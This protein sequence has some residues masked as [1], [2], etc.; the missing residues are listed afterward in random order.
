MTEA[1]VVGTWTGESKMAGSDSVVAH[2]TN[3]CGG[4]SCTAT[5]QENTDTVRATYT[6]DADSSHGVSAPYVA[7]NMGGARVVQ[8][9]I[10]RAS[11]NAVTGNSWV[12]LADKPDSVLARTTFTGTRK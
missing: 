10:A 7:S 2:W 3:V 5:T 11:G 12:V 9:W 1:D 6:M 4:G 8:H